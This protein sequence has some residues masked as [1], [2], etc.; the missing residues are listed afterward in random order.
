MI[1]NLMEVALMKI[2]LLFF[3][4]PV[5]KF[6]FELYRGQATVDDNCRYWELRR[7]FGGVEPPVMRSNADFDV[8]S[9]HHVRGDFDYFRYLVASIYQYQFHEALCRKAGEYVP[10]DAE[11]SIHNCDIF[12]SVEAG[13]VLKEMMQLGA[14]K[15]WPEA[16]EVITGQRRIDSGPA[17][18]YF[19]PL[20]EWLVRFNKE[21]DVFVG[22]EPSN[23]K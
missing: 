3:G 13:L 16:M 22:W 7:I 18:Q 11:K 23:S 9:L 17:L 6:R 8:A 5:D 21:N 20:Y 10:G 12:G 15:P 1:N 14:S 2:V 4:Y 19:K